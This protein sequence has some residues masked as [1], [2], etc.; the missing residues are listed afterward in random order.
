MN[1]YFLI[2]LEFCKIGILAFGGGL[3]TIPFLLDLSETY[4][5]FSGEQLAE[6]IAI[7]QS[8]PGPIG[9]NVA[10]FAGYTTAGFWGGVLAIAGLTVPAYII[11][12]VFS[13]YIEKYY[14]HKIVQD[15][16]FGM[17]AASVA[18]ILAAGIDIAK[19]SILDIKSLIMLIASFIFIHFVKANIFIYIIGSAI[20][21]I[22]FKL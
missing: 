15:S 18:L 10:M 22:L 13:K 9:N 14:N 3:V 5:W 4:Q 7:S 2:F 19:I 16:L 17:R 21:G 8:I 11:V 6:M 12:A 1:I 20:I